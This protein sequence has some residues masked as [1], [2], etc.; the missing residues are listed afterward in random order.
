[1]AQKIPFEIRE[2]VVQAC[3]KAFWLKDPFRAFLVGAGVPPETY[4]RYA[5]ESKYKIARH[6]LAELDGHPQGFE[7][8]RRLITELCGLR[9]VPDENV[10]DRDAA[11]QALRWLKQ[12][13]ID[14]KLL[15]EEA[16]SVSGQRAQEA[17]RKQAAIV[18]RAEKMEEL[19]R[20]Y[21]ALLARGEDP[22]GRGYRL[23]ELLAELFQVHEIPYRPPYR[24]STEQIDG[25][26]EYK[27]F[28]YLVEARWRATPPIEADLAAF[29]LK[30]DKKL[31]SSRGLF[32]SVVGFRPEVVVEFTRGVTSNI[33]LFS[34][35]DLALVLE[36]QVSLIDALEL[37]I[38]KAAQEGIIFFPLAQRFS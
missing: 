35:E 3:G 7:I 9:N 11:L 15:V 4:D 17:R 38:Q 28:P 20:A 5:G 13:A 34:G 21:Q 27:G 19:R 36:G 10:P 30:A 22:Q 14:Q 29:K 6:V 18:A 33:V 24:T 31:T 2:A 25:H 26:F 16:R 32:V 23:E 1:V 8:Q 12:L 37:K